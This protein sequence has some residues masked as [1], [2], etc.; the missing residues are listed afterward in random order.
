MY[1]PGRYDGR[2]TVFKAAEYRAPRP[3]IGWGLVCDDVECHEIPGTH[4]SFITR[5]VA[6]LGERLRACLRTARGE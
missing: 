2:V 6:T 5:H 3:D 4:L 1:V